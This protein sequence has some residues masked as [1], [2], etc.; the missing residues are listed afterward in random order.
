MIQAFSIF[1]L[2][3]N[4]LFFGVLAIYFIRLSEK[5]LLQQ[6]E[7]NRS[8]LIDI[9]KNIPDKLTSF[10]LIGNES[11]KSSTGLHNS[12]GSYI[13]G[14]RKEEERGILLKSNVI[15]N[16]ISKKQVSIIP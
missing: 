7:I 8:E 16:T 5:S 11:S 14:R 2:V 12:D 1:S 9:N 4:I 15:Y 3:R 13:K 10:T 6:E